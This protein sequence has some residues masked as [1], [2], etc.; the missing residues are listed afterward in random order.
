MSNN[1]VNWNN[2]KVRKLTL[3]ID[4]SLTCASI[5]FGFYNIHCIK[6]Q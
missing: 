5:I 4:T 2:N 6:G 1:K 3:K